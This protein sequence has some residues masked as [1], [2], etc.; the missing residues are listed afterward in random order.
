[1]FVDLIE[2]DIALDEIST[3]GLTESKVD[4]LT[5]IILKNPTLTPDQ[6]IEIAYQLDS[7]KKL[8]LNDGKEFSINPILNES[9]CVNLMELVIPVITKY[10][11]T[12]ILKHFNESHVKSITDK[13]LNIPFDDNT[14][15]FELRERIDEMFSSGDMSIPIQGLR[16]EPSSIEVVMH[17]IFAPILYKGIQFG[18]EHYAPLSVS[19]CKNKLILRD[20]LKAYTLV[21]ND[22]TLIQLLPKYIITLKKLLGNM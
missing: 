6:L 22:T 11:P 19:Q 14:S 1:M 20:A 4:V 17:G 3:I 8:I 18:K 21:D 7:N 5:E 12:N 16:K 13:I 2:Y 15:I 9:K 10:I